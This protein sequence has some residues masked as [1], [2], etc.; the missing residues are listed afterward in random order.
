MGRV[1]KAGDEDWPEV[2]VILQKIRNIWWRMLQILIQEGV[3]PKLSGRLFKAV[4]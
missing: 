1:M 3:D 2:T 4:V